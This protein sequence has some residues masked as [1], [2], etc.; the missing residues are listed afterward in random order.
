[1]RF[2]RSYFGQHCS[3][4]ER[5]RAKNGFGSQQNLE[6]FRSLLGGQFLVLPAKYGIHGVA[7]HRDEPIHFRLSYS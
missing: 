3:R 6:F 1:M 2:A 4:W 5:A 7:R